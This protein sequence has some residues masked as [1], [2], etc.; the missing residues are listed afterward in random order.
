MHERSHP[1]PVT[2]DIIRIVLYATSEQAWRSK[3]NEA[4]TWLYLGVVEID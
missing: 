3:D 2:T 4:S 1:F